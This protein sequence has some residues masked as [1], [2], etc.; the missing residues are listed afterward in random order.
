MYILKKWYCLLFFIHERMLWWSFPDNSL[1]YHIVAATVMFL[2]LKG[3][4]VTGAVYSSHKLVRNSSG[5][6]SKSHAVG[7]LLNNDDSNLR[8]V[9]RTTAQ[10]LL[11]L[12]LYIYIVL[13][14]SNF[15]NPVQVNLHFVLHLASYFCSKS[16]QPTCSKSHQKLPNPAQIHSKHL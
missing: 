4:T 9:C 16:A 14:A 3:W 6:L 2:Q 11:H 5:R 15:V 1:F 13:I 8:R 7:S 12:C 10:G